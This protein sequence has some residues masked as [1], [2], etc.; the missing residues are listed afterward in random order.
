MNSFPFGNVK[1]V[2]FCMHAMLFFDLQ[3][4]F[5]SKND[6]SMKADLRGFTLKKLSNEKYEKLFHYF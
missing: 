2:A 4:F 1:N 3:R 5:H 6:N